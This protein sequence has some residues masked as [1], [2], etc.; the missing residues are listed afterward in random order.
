M[1]VT[2]SAMLPMR[3]PFEAKRGVPEVEASES[4]WDAVSSSSNSAAAAE[5]ERVGV[6]GVDQKRERREEAVGLA[7]ALE[8]AV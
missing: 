3:W 2:S 8:A 4:A 6:V 1:V 7:E 5:E